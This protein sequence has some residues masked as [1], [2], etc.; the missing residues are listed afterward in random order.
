LRRCTKD[1][2]VSW[3]NFV[4]PKAREMMPGGALQLASITTWVESAPG[5]N[6]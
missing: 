3:F 2:L 5:F 1:V 4:K 6:A